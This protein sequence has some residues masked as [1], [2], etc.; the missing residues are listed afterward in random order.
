MKKLIV[1]SNNEH[2]IKEI[3]EILKDF[4]MEILSL[5][6]V[7]ID[8]DI[9]ENG[10]TFMENAAIKAN[11]IFNIMSDYMVMADDTGLMVDALNGAPGVYSARFAGEHANF[12]KNNEKLLNLLR[13][14][15]FEKRTAKF[16]CAIVLIV[17]K[18]TVINVEGESKGYITDKY[19]GD[20]GFGYDP[21]FYVP[22]FD[23]TFAQMTSE[24]KNSISHRGNA[25]QKLV[26]EM[27]KLKLI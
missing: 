16:V 12:K 3:R 14:V 7:G 1:A 26:E 21:L 23:K 11:T 20:S 5:K 4:N 13:D 10:T 24:Q 2:K 22:E 6:D 27:N 8:I 9:E 18:D 17:D 15:P 19:V 25:L